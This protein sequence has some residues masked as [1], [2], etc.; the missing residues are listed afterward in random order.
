MKTIPVNKTELLQQLEAVEPGLSPAATV[1]QSD[2]FVFRKGMVY[3]FDGR[4]LCR[5]RTALPKDFTC[6]V[7]GDS[8]LKAMRK[9]TLENVEVRLENGEFIVSGKRDDICVRADPKIHLPISK[10]ERPGSWSPLPPEFSE[11]IL[12][13]S[14]CAGRDDNVFLTT[15]VHVHPKWVEATDNFDF[16]RFRVRTRVS[17]PTL[18]RAKDIKPIATRGP[19]QIAETDRWLHFR[20]GSGLR[21]SIERYDPAEYNGENLHELT[22]A[23]KVRGEPTTFPKSMV[24]ATKLAEIF[25]SENKDNNVVTVSLRRN[26]ATVTGV[27]VSGR[28]LHRSKIQ[29]S[30]PE[31]EFTI[32]PEMF[33]N[34]IDRHSEVEMGDGRI[35]VIGPKWYFQTEAKEI[36]RHER[37]G[38]V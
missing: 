20:N 13:V 10:V 1:D 22:A 8:L 12:L 35:I 21:I 28:A 32:G 23:T 11:A 27:G 19:T 14:E 29:Y 33:A 16:G 7:H 15:C 30:G 5:T 3:T 26:R 34:L 24:S 6:A 17:A 9:L 36:K 4:S 18:V 2:S 38:K 37:N 31:V 25:S